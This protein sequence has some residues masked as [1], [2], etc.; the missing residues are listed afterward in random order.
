MPMNQAL[1]AEFDTEMPKTR[2]TLA[3]IPDDK[4]DWKPHP[5]SS[6]MGALAVHIATMP[7]WLADTFASESFDFAVGGKMF[8]MPTAKNRKELLALFDKG[9]AS[10]RAG[11]E[12][13]TDE[14]LM[15]TW[16]LLQNGQ[17]VFAMPR[18]VVFRGMIMNHIIHHRAQLGV[19]YRLNDIPVPA[20][21][22]PSA[23]EETLAAA[24]G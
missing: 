14:Q 6:A 9:A 7:G 20:L 18:A 10:A 11:L 16:T 19:Y 12:K 4:F 17:T 2:N 1:L 13:A 23:D 21:F 8:E 24:A 22:G 3:R 5:K 15:Q